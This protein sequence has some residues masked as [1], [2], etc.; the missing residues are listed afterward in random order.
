MNT[1]TPK[2]LEWGLITNHLNKDIIEY[3]IPDYQ[4]IYYPVFRNIEAAKY[5]IAAIYNRL[6][7]H[8]Y[9]QLDIVCT[10]TSG[11]TLATLL[12]S[13][14]PYIN[15]IDTNNGYKLLYIHKDND[16]AHSIGYFASSIYARNCP[17]LILDDLTSGGDT[18][19]RLISKLVH[20][21]QQ[22][23]IEVIACKH[24]GTY[25]ATRNKY[26]SPHLSNLKLIIQ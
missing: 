5:L 11:L 21:K 4:Q 13:L 20:H 1:Q 15:S 2:L 10:G 25:L 19:N 23:R 17:I 12:S 14:Y 7:Y 24:T 6:R 9:Q 26:I 22:H 16:H 8:N 3:S 18:L